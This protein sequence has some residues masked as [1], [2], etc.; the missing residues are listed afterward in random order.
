MSNNCDGASN[1]QALASGVNSG[2]WQSKIWNDTMKNGVFYAHG[3]CPVCGSAVDTS[4]PGAVVS[5]YRQGDTIDVDFDISA[6]HAGGM[7][8]RLCDL[9]TS[10][11]GCTQY[12]D[13]GEP[14]ENAESG[15]GML[16]LSPSLYTH[17]HTHA[18]T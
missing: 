14:L 6:N 7:Q 13:F 2:D 11:S 1:A 15:G 9:A 8:V 10:S 4:S 17:T 18:R 3:G 5:T 16:S 12:Q